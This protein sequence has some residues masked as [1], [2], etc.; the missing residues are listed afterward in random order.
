[1][2]V[3]SPETVISYSELEKEYKEIVNLGY[4]A[5]EPL[6]NNPNNINF[7]KLKEILTK[8]NLKISGL[9]TGLAYLKD[10][11]SFSNPDTIIRKKAIKRLKD[12]IVL[13]S[14]FNTSILVGLMQGKLEKRVSVSQAKGWIIDSLIECTDFAQNKNVMIK[15]E[16]INRYQLNYNNTITEVIGIID[17][18]KSDYLSLLIDSYHMHIEEKSTTDSINLAHRYISH[19]HLS[20]SNRDAPNSTGEINFTNIIKS[21]GCRCRDYRNKGRY[22]F[23]KRS[24]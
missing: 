10:G 20:S 17:K 18:V 24:T 2:A 11:I 9:R 12:D 6:V 8:L 14:K 4:F 19:V 21:F 7:K 3:P 13:A 16:P 5:I 23:S 22:F 1:M 15:L